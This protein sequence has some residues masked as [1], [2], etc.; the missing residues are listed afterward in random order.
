MG[1]QPS[2]YCCSSTAPSPVWLASHF[3]RVFRCLSKCF[4]SVIFAISAFILSKAVVCESSQRI[5]LFV[6]FSFFNRGLIG[7]STLARLGINFMSWC[8]EPIR[9][10]NCLSV[11]GGFK[12]SIES[13]FFTVGDIPDW[14][15]LYPSQMIEDFANSHFSNLIA[16]FSLSSL[17]RTLYMSNSCSWGEPFVMISMSSK[18]LN[19]LSMFSRVLSKVFWN[20]AGISLRP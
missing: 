19:L 8:I 9:E 1:N 6:M 20:V 12:Y 11:F 15:I 3:R 14:V 16:K 17:D 2:G 4:F 5:L 13:V 7:L 18:K 10:R